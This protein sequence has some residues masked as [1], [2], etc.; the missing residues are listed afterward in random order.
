MTACATTVIERLQLSCIKDTPD[1]LHWINK[2]ELAEWKG[3]F[4]LTG[5]GRLRHVVLIENQAWGMAAYRSVTGPSAL[6]VAN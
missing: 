5:F 3:R 6:V 2:F 4:V 1:P